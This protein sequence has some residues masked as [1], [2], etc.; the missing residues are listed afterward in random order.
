MWVKVE[1][2][3]DE[4]RVVFGQLDSEPI[5]LTDLRLGMELAVSYDKICEHM[6]AN[7]SLA[8]NLAETR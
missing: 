2:A 3:D 4:L 6:K 7:A 5:V 1:H 8:R